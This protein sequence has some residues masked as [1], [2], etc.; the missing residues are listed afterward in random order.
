MWKLWWPDNRCWGTA[1]L[2]TALRL[3]LK[4]SLR[5]RRDDGKFWG[6]VQAL[7]QHQKKCFFFLSSFL[8]ALESG[9]WFTIHQ[10]WLKSGENLTFRR[11]WR[12]GPLTV[13]EW[14]ALC[15]LLGGEASSTHSPAGSPLSEHSWGAHGV[16]GAPPHQ[17]TRKLLPGSFFS[18]GG[19]GHAL[20]SSFQRA[21]RSQ[22]KLRS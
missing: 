10:L 20:P 13:S 14:T 8:G 5:K 21:L 11:P 18:G 17:A 3:G 4:S 6:Q 7:Y 2:A 19:P 16:G 22:C 12:K 15:F 9:K 1:E